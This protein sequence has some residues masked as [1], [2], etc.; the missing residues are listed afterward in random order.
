MNNEL[1]SAFFSGLLELIGGL[2]PISLVFIGFVAYE[3]ATTN[4]DKPIATVE[5]VE[6]E[7]EIIFIRPPTQEE[8]ERAKKFE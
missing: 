2:I 5:I 4:T 8:I 1:Q 3:T 6:E 7:I